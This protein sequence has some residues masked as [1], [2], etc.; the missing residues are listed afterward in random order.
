MTHPQYGNDMP[1]PVAR[2]AEVDLNA[3]SV[4]ERLYVIS[5]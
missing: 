2:G 1:T 3:S 5:F 4:N